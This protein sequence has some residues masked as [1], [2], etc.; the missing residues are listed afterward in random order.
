[1]TDASV[2]AYFPPFPNAGESEQGY[3]TVP[4][5]MKIASGCIMN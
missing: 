3:S 5:S 2:P 4:V 1:M